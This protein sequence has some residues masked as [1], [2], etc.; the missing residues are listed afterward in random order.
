MGRLVGVLAAGWILLFCLLFH[1]VISDLHSQADNQVVT[2]AQLPASGRQLATEQSSS[3][4]ARH[5]QETFTSYEFLAYTAE[6]HWDITHQQLSLQW[7][8]NVSQRQ[9]VVVSA[10]SADTGLPVFYLIWQDLRNDEG[11]IY[12]K[13]S[14]TGA[15]GFGQPIGVSTVMMERLPSLPP[16]QLS[17]RR[18]IC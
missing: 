1:R 7:Q 13:S 16:P 14:M 8:D 18:A 5:F 11:D 4:T 9:V 2:V 3:N 10:P 17:I 15:T 6:T 12:P